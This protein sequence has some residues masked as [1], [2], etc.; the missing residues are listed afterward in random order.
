M[1]DIIKENKIKNFLPL[2]KTHKQI[3]YYELLTYYNFNGKYQT[4]EKHLQDIAG[5]R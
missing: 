2:P 3:I 4:L 5:T 1:N